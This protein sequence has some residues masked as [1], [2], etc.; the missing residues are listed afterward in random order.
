MYPMIIS[1]STSCCARCCENRFTPQPSATLNSSDHLDILAY[2]SSKHTTWV[3]L[4]AYLQGFRSEWRIRLISHSRYWYMRTS[5]D[6]DHT[7]TSSSPIARTGRIHRIDE[8][9]DS[10][11]RAYG[12]LVHAMRGRPRCG[13]S[14]KLLQA[15]LKA[16]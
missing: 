10:L 11:W 13:A 5:G 1:L 9:Q 4:L 14:A 8:I 12:V 7:H 3:Y 2:L 16:A 15:S 6:F